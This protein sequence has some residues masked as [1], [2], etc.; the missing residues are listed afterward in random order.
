VSSK[1]S[2]FTSASAVCSHQM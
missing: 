2:A 1:S